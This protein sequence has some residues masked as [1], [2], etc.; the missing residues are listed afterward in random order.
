MLLFTLLA[1]FFFWNGYKGESVLRAAFTWIASFGVGVGVLLAV[2]EFTARR[3]IRRA[4]EAIH[5]L[6]DPKSSKTSDGGRRSEP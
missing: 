2:N 5:S 3:T 4:E 1:L 6:R